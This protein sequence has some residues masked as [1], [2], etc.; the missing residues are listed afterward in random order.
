[1]PPP[2]GVLNPKNRMLDSSETEST[3]LPTTTWTN[4]TDIML[5]ERS[6]TQRNKYC[7]IPFIDTSRMMDAALWYA[8]S[9][10]RY[11]E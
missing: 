6:Q 1:M 9:G 11:C 3:N 2:D 7:R 4:L 5:T 8:K 10:G